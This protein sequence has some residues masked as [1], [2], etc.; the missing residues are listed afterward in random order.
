MKSLKTLH[1]NRLWDGNDEKLA[2]LSPRVLIQA[3]NIFPR[4]LILEV[5]PRAK[6]LRYTV[7]M[8]LVLIISCAGVLFSSFNVI[9]KCTGEMN[10]GGVHEGNS[11]LVVALYIIG[12][13]FA[14]L[15]F[16]FM[17][18][19][20]KYYDLLD[21]TPIYMASILVFNIVEGLI[22][23]DEYTAYT[24]NGLIGI[25]IGILCCCFGITM[26]M[27][28]N[29]DKVKTKAM[30]KDINESDEESEIQEMRYLLLKFIA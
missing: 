3:M 27:V 11:P 6:I 2:S 25:G 28:K 13:L 1:R 4:E 21:I 14:I 10:S 30:S 5:S 9:F 17:N 26:L 29:H 8:P 16:V 24:R 15:S 23:L 22:I 12:I 20:M 19:A 7:R 18:M